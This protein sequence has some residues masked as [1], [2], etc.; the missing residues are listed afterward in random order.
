MPLDFFKANLKE[1]V[2]LCCDYFLRK[3]SLISKINYLYAPNQN[4]SFL[5]SK[6]S[7]NSPQTF[8]IAKQ[9]EA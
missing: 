5:I 4:V 8:K 1:I 3:N 9:Q 2:K 7:R 6:E